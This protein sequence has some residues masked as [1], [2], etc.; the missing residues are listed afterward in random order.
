MC[1]FL[2]SELIETLWN[3]NFTEAVT[4]VAALSELIETLWNVNMVGT[5][6]PDMGH[7]ELIETLWNVNRYHS[8]FNNKRRNEN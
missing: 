5:L 8:F 4:Y 7:T 1:H 6:S 2:N 3:V